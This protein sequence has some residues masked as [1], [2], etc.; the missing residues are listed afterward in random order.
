MRFTQFLGRDK[1]DGVRL[2]AISGKKVRLLFTLYYDSKERIVVTIVI[3]H[4]FPVLCR[5]D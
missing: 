5:F 2:S 1:D 4:Y 3:T